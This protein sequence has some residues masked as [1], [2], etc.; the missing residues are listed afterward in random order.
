MNRNPT[1]LVID[2]DAERRG[3]VVKMLVMARFPV[4]G[5]AGLGVEGISLAREKQPEVMF[6]ALQEPVSRSLQAV[7]T[8]GFTLPDAPVIVYS[9]LTDPQAVRMAMV[10][11]ARD[12]LFAP[13]SSE[14]LAA[15]V[16]QV[17]GQIAARNRRRLGDELAELEMTEGTVITVFGAKG[18]IGKTTIA[19]NLATAL[20]ERAGQSVALVDMDTRFGDVA[21]M[22]DVPVER[23]IV[24]VCQHLEEFRRETVRDFLVQHPNGVYILPAPLDPAAWS[25]VTPEHI[26]KIVRVLSQTHDFVI[27]DTPGTF[28]EIVATALE[29]AT[30]VLLVTSMDMASIKDTVLALNMLRSWAFPAEKIKLT[31]NHANTANSVR[32]E[33]VE[34]TLDYDVFW[35]IPYDQ[36]VTNATQLGQPIVLSRPGSKA[37]E[38]LVELAL[39]LAGVRKRKRTGFIDRFLGRAS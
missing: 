32:E 18:G 35:R 34:R 23:S 5:D 12:Y 30:V 28:N 26:E 29:V 36:A 8:L 24:D 31:V 3:E 14:Q 38:N 19:T 37:A 15:S 17:M 39:Q 10:K 20:H 27:L 1:V 16:E 25:I 33:D 21:I 2:P 22:M 9:S 4:V 13:V 11:G 6:V 7:E